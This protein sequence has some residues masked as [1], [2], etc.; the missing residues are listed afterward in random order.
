MRLTKPRRAEFLDH[1]AATCNVRAA[2]A[3][4]GVDPIVAHRRRRSDPTFA[5]A[6][7]GAIEAGY[8]MLETWL[9]GC[10]L[11]SSGGAAPAADERAPD[12]DLD[13][14]PGYRMLRHRAEMRK[15]GRG[16]GVAATATTRDEADKQILA[17]L[18]A[19]AARRPRA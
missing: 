10:A 8:Q 13:F 1:L 9:I 5:A 4:A 2:A 3:A 14:D 16:G 6:W 11:V 12:K 18:A 15:P 7:D 17:K 19:L